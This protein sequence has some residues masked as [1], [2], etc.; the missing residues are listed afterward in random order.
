[1]VRTDHGVRVGIKYPGLYRDLVTRAIDYRAELFFEATAIREDILHNFG[2]LPYRMQ[3][4]RELDAVNR[5]AV[6]GWSPPM[7]PDRCRWC[8]QGT[9]DCASFMQALE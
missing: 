4:Q 9:C 1:V 5:D 8:N 6:R 2:R 7:T 3:R